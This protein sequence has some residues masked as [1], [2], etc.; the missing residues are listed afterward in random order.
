MSTLKH[1][2]RPRK[3]GKGHGETNTEG[4]AA[5]E[6]GWLIDAGKGAECVCV[7]VCVCVC[8]CVAG[9]WMV[10]GASLISNTSPDTV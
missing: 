1:P 6:C 2:E 8:G 4:D 5:N 7:C 3:K 9:G 10:F